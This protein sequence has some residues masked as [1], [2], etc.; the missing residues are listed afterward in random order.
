MSVLVGVSTAC[1]DVLTDIQPSVVQ[2][3]VCRNNAISIIQSQLGIDLLSL[4][5]R[6]LLSIESRRLENGM[7]L[8]SSRESGGRDK[9]LS[10]MA[11]ASKQILS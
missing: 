4:H 3:R 7:V 8:N 6:Q 9:A 10:G 11:T 2:L 5:M 1:A